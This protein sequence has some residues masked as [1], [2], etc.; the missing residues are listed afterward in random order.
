MA[1]FPPMLIVFM[2]LQQIVFVLACLGNAMVIFVFV[3][4]LKTKS[5]TNKF[6][7]SLAAAD[8]LAGI[9]SGTQI[10]Y[11]FYPG[12]SISMTSCFF[13][14]QIV[15]FTATVSLVTVMFTTFDRYI[16]I[17]HPHKYSTIMTDKNATVLCVSP[18]V[19]MFLFYLSTFVGWNEWKTGIPC[20]YL[21][22]FPRVYHC[23]SA[24]I[25]YIFSFASFVMYCFILRTAWRHYKRVKPVGGTNQQ[26]T[27]VMEKNMRSAKIMGFVAIAFTICW[28]PF[29]SVQ[30][31]YG[32]GINDNSKL[33]FTISNWLVFLGIFNSVV[34]PFIYAWK[35]RDFSRHVR[36]IMFCSRDTKPTPISSIG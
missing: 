5:N 21:I 23:I 34:N 26:N 33:A 20:M 11:F 22:I 6:I 27:N 1:A 10:L 29:I 30:F 9:S 25:L 18:W 2:T 36:K 17:C 12:L 31:R 19:S 15:G 16:A 24:M 4:Y 8:F 3:K 32:I 35:R 14:Y 28:F 13:R 7:I